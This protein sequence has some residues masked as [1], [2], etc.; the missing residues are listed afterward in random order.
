MFVE[1]KG[2][3]L[4]CKNAGLQLHSRSANSQEAVNSENKTIRRMTMMWAVAKEMD[5]AGV[6]VKYFHS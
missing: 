5:R 2:V 3:W 1:L 6:A 4:S